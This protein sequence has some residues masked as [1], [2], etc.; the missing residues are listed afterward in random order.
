MDAEIHRLRRLLDDLSRHYDQALGP[1]ELNR[2]SIE[3]NEWL[4]PVLAPW[5]E[6]AERKGL[7]WSFAPPIEPIVIEVDP[8]RLA[9]AVGNLISNAIKYTPAGDT[10]SIEIESDPAAALIHV[11][12]TGPGIPLDDQAHLF[13]PFYRSHTA[14][15]FPQGMGLGLTIARDLVVAHGGCLEVTSTLGHGSR[16]TI[17]LPRISPPQHSLA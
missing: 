6:S 2:R 9:Q 3:L 5:R 4:T 12:D 13:E 8:D 11:T 16:F 17:W 14:R 10:V 15:R 1:L 7:Q